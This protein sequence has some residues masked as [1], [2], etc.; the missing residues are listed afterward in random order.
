MRRATTT[1][2]VTQTKWHEKPPRP[3]TC[4]WDQCGQAIRG[5]D[6]LYYDNCVPMQVEHHRSD[7]TSYWLDKVPCFCSPACRINHRIGVFARRKSC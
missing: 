2:H 7:G 1:G 6:A 5:T 3:D 4:D